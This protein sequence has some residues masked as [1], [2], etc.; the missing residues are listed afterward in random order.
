VGHQHRT[1]KDTAQSQRDPPGLAGALAQPAW[2]DDG[3][4][5]GGAGV[6]APAP[7]PRIGTSS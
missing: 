3:L 1:F 6:C 5:K 2:A 4:G 7:L